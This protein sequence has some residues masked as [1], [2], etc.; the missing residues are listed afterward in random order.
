MGKQTMR[1][2]WL[3][4]CMHGGARKAQQAAKATL[5]SSV[6]TGNETWEGHV[7]CNKA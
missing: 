5:S 6:M 7:G 1:F 3:Q 2:R 4:L